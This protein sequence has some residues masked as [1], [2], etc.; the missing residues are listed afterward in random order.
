MPASPKT[1]RTSATR[2]GLL[3]VLMLLVAGTWFGSA[4]PAR[5][6]STAQAMDTQLLGLVNSE[7]VANG[8]VSLRKDSGLASWA[9]ERSLWMASHGLLTHTSWDGAPCSMYV[10]M[11]ITWYGCAEA[12]GFTT[13]KY[14]SAAATFLFNLW[15]ASPDH[16]ALLMSASYNYVGIGVSY[17]AATHTT[18]ASVLFLEGPDRSPPVVRYLHE[19]VSGHD[20]NWS[21]TGADPMLQ[22]HYA[23][24]KSYDVEISING[25]AWRRVRTG[26]T[27]IAVTIRDEKA[28]TYRLGVRARDRAGN[29]SGWLTSATLKVH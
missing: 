24:F 7:R 10:K 20:V 22:T 11:R 14:G 4:A 26:S 28:G 13:A 5:A 16:Q 29:L 21:W 18:Y 27:A 15:K 12:I 23:G 6:T 3:A 9:G 1:V 25:G 2:N 17:R 8:L 19:G